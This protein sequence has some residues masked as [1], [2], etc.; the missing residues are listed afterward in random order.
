MLFKKKTRIVNKPKNLNL[1]VTNFC[2]L[3]CPMCARTTSMSRATKH[4]DLELFKKIID[5]VVAWE[6]GGPHVKMHQ[7][8]E[9]F[10][11][12]KF[13][14]MIDYVTNS[15]VR[16][17]FSSNGTLLNEKNIEKILSVKSKVR[18]MLSLDAATEKTYNFVR[19]QPSGKSYPFEKVM[20]N[21]ELLLR[22]H[23]EMK[24]KLRI[25]LTIVDMPIKGNEIELFR[26]RWGKYVDGKKVKIHVAKFTAF[27]GAVDDVKQFGIGDDH[28]ST[29]KKTYPRKACGAVEREMT[30]QS[31]GHSVACCYDVNGEIKLGNARDK[32]L[33]DIWYDAQYNDLRSKH[34][35]LD[36][37]T[38]PLCDG[39][40]LTYKL[41]TEENSA[42]LD[43]DAKA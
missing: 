38:I 6:G 18:M 12:P 26:E 2:N 31:D 1:E 22:K 7:F 13:F 20:N 25:T 41:P 19:S 28:P 10:M 16:C 14:E 40:T 42:L 8:G 24:S 32:S 35:N 21:V 29:R 39:C 5:D 3:A 23:Q 33:R 30:I 34:R 9:A 43:V 27:G 4:M 37:K 36:F 11:H 15:G 17:S